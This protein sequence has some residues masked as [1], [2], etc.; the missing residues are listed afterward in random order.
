MNASQAPNIA[1]PAA[2]LR[3]ALQFVPTVLV[4]L[5]L[6]GAAVWGHR[7]GWTLPKFSEL[8]GN[9][10]AAGEDWCDEH[11]VPES[12]CV[13]CNPK[14][15]PPPPHFGWCKHHGVHD[16]P[17]EH[18]QVA[19]L[20]QGPS[21]PSAEI[22]R[23]RLAL[24]LKDRPANSKNCKM[25]QRRIQVTSL[26]ALA[27]M[28]VDVLPVAAAPVV[29]AATASAELVYEQPSVAPVALLVAGRVRSLTDQARLGAAVKQGDVLALV[30]AP[31]VGKVKSDLLQAL[32]QVEFKQ[33][34]HDNI[35]DLAAKGLKQQNEV[36][37]AESALREAHLHLI[38]AQQALLN[39]GLPTNLES[40]R[41]LAPDEL[42]KRMQFLG[43]PEAL[44]RDLD[45]Q[46]TSASLLPVKAPRAGTIIASKVAA[47]EVVD[48]SK[49]L[50]VIADTRR[51]WLFLHVRMED[52]RYLRARDE[53]TRTPGQSVLFRPDGGGP[54][55]TGE[56]T[57]ISTEVDEKTRT[58]QARAEIANPDGK[59]RAFT[60]GQGRVVLRVD[61]KA[62]V[63]PSQAVH[64]DGACHIVFV[65][66]RNWF[67]EGSPKVFHVRT[68]RPGVK[69][70]DTTE[71][72]VGLVPGEVIATHNSAALRAEL[73]KGQLGEC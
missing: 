46:T 11:G 3:R 63:V 62:V 44:T 30:E 32:G 37:E 51:L 47:G 14:E 17:L 36:R 38:A 29:E 15:Y 39:L 28:G 2:P 9:G 71:V 27:K 12:L 10:Q 23:V 57:W 52:I 13:E 21:V 31:E 72:I 42:A 22:E 67:K 40:L 53:A 73:L 55:V 18:P 1:R 6:G 26:A 41:G 19:Q 16:C 5:V 25:H 69:E 60:F 64:W 43:L 68:V 50:F 35:K 59:L 45:P 24:S 65:R 58:V 61:E 56:L 34:L 48:A 7:T 8:I 54:E 20:A 4:L 33:R 49:T 70:N 66:D